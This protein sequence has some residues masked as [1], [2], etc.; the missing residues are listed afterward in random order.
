MAEFRNVC[1]VAEFA[2]GEARAFEVQGKMIAIFCQQGEYFAIDDTCPHMGAS[3]SE[4]YVE[5]GVVTCPWHAWRFRIADGAWADNP[6]IKTGSYPVRI[7]Q[8]MIQVQV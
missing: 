6:C 3:L 8:G 1:S 7:E 4:G 5:R 2:E